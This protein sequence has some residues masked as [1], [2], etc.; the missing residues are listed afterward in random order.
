M[1]L[2]LS[3]L[4]KLF[5]KSKGAE[6]HK[7]SVFQGRGIDDAMRCDEIYLLEHTG[8]VL[9]FQTL[10]SMLSIPRFAFQVCVAS[11]IVQPL[12]HKVYIPGSFS[13]LR[14]PNFIL[15]ISF[16]K[17]YILTIYGEFCVPGYFILGTLA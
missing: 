11:F 17:M 6:S 1:F 9:A 4:L 13:K 15:Q 3:I 16:S 2:H 12:H 7:K 5:Q 14:I 8:V 10:C